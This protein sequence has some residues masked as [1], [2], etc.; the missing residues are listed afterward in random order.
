MPDQAQPELT[1]SLLSVRAGSP[2]VE[3]EQEV[4]VAAGAFRWLSVLVVKI[5]RI[6]EFEFEFEF[7][8][9]SGHLLG[10]VPLC[11][12]LLPAINVNIQ[13]TTTTATTTAI[14]SKSFYLLHLFI[15]RFITTNRN[16]RID[17]KTKWN[18]A[19]RFECIL[20]E[21]KWEFILLFVF[22]FRDS[23]CS[24]FEA[25]SSCNELNRTWGEQ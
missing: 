14:S 11:D 7:E 1:P 17:N 6:F 20:S 8:L 18:E 2:Q 5:N 16:R 15:L 10:A 25:L 9:I 12:M 22:D 24:I 23:K 3:T 21:I 19:K 13:P 4:K